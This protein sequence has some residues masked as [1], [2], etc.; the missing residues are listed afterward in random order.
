MDMLFEVSGDS[1]IFST[2]LFTMCQCLIAQSYLDS[3]I[4]IKHQIVKTICTLS[5]ALTL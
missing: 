2:N 1:V 4:K 3:Y 5:A